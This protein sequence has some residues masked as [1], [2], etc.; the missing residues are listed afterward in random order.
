M[1]YRL[2]RAK[3]AMPNVECINFKDRSIYDQ[4]RE[5][6][7]YGAPSLIHLAVP[8]HYC[9]LSVLCLLQRLVKATSSHSP[10]LCNISDVVKYSCCNIAQPNSTLLWLCAGPDV[11][12]ECVGMHY[13]ECVSLISAGTVR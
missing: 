1:E 6:L 3:E 11:G 2:K 13:M 5:K 10:N 4:V 7:P 12:I 9:S 8:A